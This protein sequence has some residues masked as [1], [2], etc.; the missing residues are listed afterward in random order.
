MLYASCFEPD[1]KA[2]VAGASLG[3]NESESYL[4][5]PAKWLANY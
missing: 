5:H 2:R 4:Q 1:S 3:R